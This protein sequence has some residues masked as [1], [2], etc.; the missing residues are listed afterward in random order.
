MQ[1]ETAYLNWTIWTVLAWLGGSRI[2]PCLQLICRAI[3]GFSFS[4]FNL[5]ICS[6]LPTPC[7]NFFP[8]LEQWL[9]ASC[10]GK[11]LNMCTGKLFPP[12]QIAN[13]AMKGL[14]FIRGVSCFASWS[15]LFLSSV[16]YQ[17]LTSLDFK[18]HAWMKKPD[19]LSHR[20][21]LKNSCW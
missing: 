14:V 8:L 6:Y 20:S 17:T 10:E 5:N 15:L 3:L 18:S 16:R 7:T 19:L 4:G 2:K 13:S 12:R 21:C 11:Y 9:I 1:S